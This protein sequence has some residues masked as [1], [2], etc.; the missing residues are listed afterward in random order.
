MAKI[1]SMVGIAKGKMGSIV[2]SVRNGQQIARQYQPYVSNPSTQSQVNSRARLKL[3]SQLSAS[4]GNVIAIPREGDK[5]SRNLFTKV[6]HKYTQAQNG[7]ATIALADMQLTKSAVGLE[8]FIADRTSGLKI[9]IELKAD[10]SAAFDKV[11]YVVVQ[12][13][14]SGALQPFASAVIDQ[15]G[16][17]GTFPAELPY[18][19]AAISVHAYGIKTE[20]ADARAAFDKMTVP[21]AQSVAQVIA[22]RQ[23]N[24]TGLTLS[25]TRGLFME[26]GTDQQ[27]TS[28]KI[29]FTLNIQRH[30]IEGMPFGEAGTVTGAG[31]YEQNDTVDVTASPNAGYRFVGWKWTDDGAIISNNPS[32]HIVMTENKS[33]IAVFAEIAS[34]HTV[35]LLK[36]DS[37]AGA[38]VN[39]TGGGVHE[40]GESVTVSASIQGA[41]TNKRWCSDAA[42][43][44]EVHAGDSYTFEMPGSDVTLYFCATNQD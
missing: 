26:E 15:P 28:G 25:E 11:V 21:D 3:L 18:T 33:I 31:R 22:S 34:S 7:V 39:F 35:T 17:G 44:T 5:S 1:T 16:E 38:N 43:T 41:W 6:N 12:R 42:G 40:D 4:V 10:V 29:Y 37:V 30:D 23:V 36:G 32:H 13:L 2:Y 14:D 20:S 24:T 27:E 19:D 8:G 9:A